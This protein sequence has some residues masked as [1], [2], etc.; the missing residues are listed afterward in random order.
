MAMYDQLRL[1]KFLVFII[2]VL[3]LNPRLWSQKGE[4]EYAFKFRSVLSTSSSDITRSR[5]NGAYGVYVTYGVTDWLNLSAGLEVQGQ[6]FRYK[7]PDVCHPLIEA[8]LWDI[9]GEEYPGCGSRSSDKYLKER[10]IVGRV[11]FIASLN[12]SEDYSAK[13]QTYL[14]LGYAYGRASFSGEI[15]ADYSYDLPFKQNLHYGIIGLEFKSVGD[16]M[17]MTTGA[18]VEFTR[19][20]YYLFG[21]VYNYTL[22][23]RVGF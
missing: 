15:R 10:I 21:R 3:F 8:I 22:G 18:Y 2:A 17:S 6:G 4:M 20:D 1:M 7:N 11:P 12:L 16:K 23:V 19:L 9:I 13:T 14:A 5:V